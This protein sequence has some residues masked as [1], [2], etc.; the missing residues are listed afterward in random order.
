MEAFSF[1]DCLA[2]PDTHMFCVSEAGG[3]EAI[4]ILLQTL[5]PYYTVRGNML[6]SQGGESTILVSA[7][8]M[9]SYSMPSV[10]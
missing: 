7:L 1:F 5:L 3:A 6:K 4:S 9:G 2:K 8:S 10:C